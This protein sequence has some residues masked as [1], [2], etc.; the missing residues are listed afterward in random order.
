MAEEIKINITAKDKAAKAIGKITS[1]IAGLAKAGLAAAASIASAGLA[2]GALAGVA[3]FGLA[4]RAASKFENR[5]TEISTLL[6]GDVVPAMDHFKIAIKDMS[7]ELPQTAD[8][9]GAGL[10]DVL[11]AG[12]TDTAEAMDVLRISA[13]AGIAG[14]S[15]TKVAAD[16]VT[17]VLNAY[18]LS[19]SLASDVSDLMFTTIRLGKT[20]FEQLAPKIGF[21]VATASAAGVAFGELSAAIATLTAGGIKTEQTVTSLNQAILSFVKPTEGMQDA[22]KAIGIES[23]TAAIKQ[24]GFKGALD[25]VIGTT[26]GS[27][28]SITELFESV[29]ALKAVLGL[30]GVSSERFTQS[31]AEMGIAG[32]ATEIAFTKMSAT[33]SNQFKLLRNIINVVL[34]DIGEKLLPTLTR[35]ITEIS[36]AL[37][38]PQIQS[39]IALF[40]EFFGKAFNA[41][42]N[43]AKELLTNSGAVAKKLVNLWRIEFIIIKKIFESMK[44]VLS[45]IWGTMLNDLEK[46]VVDSLNKML[47]QFEI[48]LRG[49][50]TFNVF[51]KE[52]LIFPDIKFPRLLDVEDFVP[53]KFKLDLEEEIKEITKILGS[54]VDFTGLTGPEAETLSTKISD[55]LLGG[56]G[57]GGGGA[58][59]GLRVT[60]PGVTVPGITGPGVTTPGV[61]QINNPVFETNIEVQKI[62]D[63]NIEGLVDKINRLQ[64]DKLSSRTNVFVGS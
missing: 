44:V 29:E 36:G 63:S 4:I 59:T 37:N 48:F 6:T 14:L 3:V 15:D 2:I 57:P 23:G 17:T 8:E 40:A 10:Y 38:S 20:T 7:K 25:A 35:T 49:L 39:A 53:E 31:L 33:F 27:I 13:K 19:A 26:D 64:L 11:S 56:G 43:L 50:N 51:G 9:L 55:L 5:M 1:K 30:T 18:N 32:G 34:I 22:L 45:N 60:T 41:I 58:G 52:I 54:F 16:A 47:T 46:L 28:E 42:I 21:V 12:I 62:D 24:L 61:V